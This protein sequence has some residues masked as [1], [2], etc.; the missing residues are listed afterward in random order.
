MLNHFKDSISLDHISV[1]H[2]NCPKIIK[3]ENVAEPYSLRVTALNANHCPGSVMFLFEKLG[4]DGQVELRVLYT[5]DFRSEW[6]THCGGPR[7]PLRHCIHYI[8]FQCH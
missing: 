1:V 3:I 7:F 6:S 2:L 4:G 5:G 8:S